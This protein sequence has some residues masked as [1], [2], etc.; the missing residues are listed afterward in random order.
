MQYPEFNLGISLEVAASWHG[1]WESSIATTWKLT[2]KA[3][4]ISMVD[5][6]SPAAAPVSVY[7]GKLEAAGPSINSALHRGTERERR[8]IV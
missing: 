4:W 8:S 7:L 1:A 5:K 6:H 2:R 3:G